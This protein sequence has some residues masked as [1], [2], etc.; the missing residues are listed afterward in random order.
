MFG[1]GAIWSGFKRLAAAVN[2]LA[3]DVESIR[4]LL[5]HSPVPEDEQRPAL[6]V[7]VE[8]PLAQ[9][10]Q[11]GQAAVEAGTNGNGRGRKA[12]RV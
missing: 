8:Q 4:G 2:G 9:T 6:P 3:D 11:D 7:I 12:A 10:T 1:L 5:R